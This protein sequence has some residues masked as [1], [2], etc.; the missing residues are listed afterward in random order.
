MLKMMLRQPAM[1]SS[2]PMTVDWPRGYELTTVAV[3]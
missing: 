2:K 1:M 3:W